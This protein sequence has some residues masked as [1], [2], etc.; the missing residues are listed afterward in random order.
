MD[1][2]WDK[3]KLITKIRAKTETPIEF[4]KVSEPPLPHYPP[5]AVSVDHI[6][7]ALSEYKERGLVVTYTKESVRLTRTMG[8]T[9][10]D[11]SC[12]LT[13]PLK[14]IMDCARRVME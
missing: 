8:K 1:W 3:P 11:D 14:T 5:Y 2:K 4:P 9:T 13:A 10:K 6:D 12:S 7:S